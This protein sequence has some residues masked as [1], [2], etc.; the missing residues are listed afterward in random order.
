MNTSNSETEKLFV[1]RILF[2]D[3]N[4][5]TQI[6]VPSFFISRVLDAFS[7]PCN[8]LLLIATSLGIIK[9]QRCSTLLHTHESRCCI[10]T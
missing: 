5:G 2:S 6:L 4:T 1:Y 7:H 10:S 9:Y 8:C 3:K